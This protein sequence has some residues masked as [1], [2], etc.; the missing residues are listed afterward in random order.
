MSAWDVVSQAILLLAGATFW[1]GEIGVATNP[2]S[3]VKVRYGRSDAL[4][5]VEVNLTRSAVGV[6]EL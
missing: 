1:P 2:F 4:P 5:S 6:Y 3:H